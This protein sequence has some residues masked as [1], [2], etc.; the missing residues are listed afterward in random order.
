MSSILD[1][2]LDYFAI[3][4]NPVKR[5]KDLLE[6]GNQ[7]VE[8]IVE[9]HHKILKQWETCI[10][11]GIIDPP[12]YVLHVDEH[13][14]TMDEKRTPNVANFIYHAM[15]KWTNCHVHWLVEQPIDSPEMWLS[16]NAWNTINQRFSIGAQRPQ[17]WPKP[18]L[19]SVC[20]S[21][22]FIDKTLR[23]RLQEHID[24]WDDMFNFLN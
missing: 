17:D 3:L 16:E 18:D 8:I 10:K 2:D 13:H 22:E 1:I 11:K 5:L 20:T 23:C 14:D 4:D 15:R 21:P 12:T 9:Q 24:L 19:V 7:P 6:W